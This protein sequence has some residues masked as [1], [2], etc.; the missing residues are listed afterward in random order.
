MSKLT[1]AE[2]TLYLHNFI[3]KYKDVTQITSKHVLDDLQWVEREFDLTEEV[4]Y[5]VDRVLIAEKE[6]YYDS[7]RDSFNVEHE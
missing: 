7:I 2:I 5:M 4:K 3:K 6:S 1:R